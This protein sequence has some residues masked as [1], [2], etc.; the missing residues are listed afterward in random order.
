MMRST[1]VISFKNL[2]TGMAFILFSEASSVDLLSFKT[3]NIKQ[4]N[5]AH[6]YSSIKE[7]EKIH[8]GNLAKYV[9]KH[10]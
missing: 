10:D 8:D 7:S 1:R 9:N 3:K 2:V 4:L 5:N 6:I